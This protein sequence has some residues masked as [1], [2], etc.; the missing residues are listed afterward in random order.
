MEA[1]G[2]NI[3][4]DYRKQIYINDNSTIEQDYSGLHINL[5][6]GLQGVQPQKDPYT[7]DKLLGFS[8]DAQRKI[9]KGLA[10]MGI[11]ARS[12]QKAFSAFRNEQPTGSLEKTLKDKQLQILLDAFKEKTPSNC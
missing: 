10:L 2:K 4:E 9:V 5:L 7:L 3:K 6:Y 1:G 12:P 8:A 11:N